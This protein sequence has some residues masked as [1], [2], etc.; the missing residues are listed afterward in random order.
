MTGGEGDRTQ[1]FLLP[2]KEAD[3]MML[4]PPLSPLEVVK[5]G[6]DVNRICIGRGVKVDA[7][8]TAELSC[9]LMEN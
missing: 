8:V 3:I 4:L 1:H 6:R 2:I 9:K 7:Y 5:N